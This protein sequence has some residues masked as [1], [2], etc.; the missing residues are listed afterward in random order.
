[1]SRMTCRPCSRPH[2]LL[3][4]AG[5]ARNEVRASLRGAPSPPFEGSSKLR[6]GEKLWRRGGDSRGCNTCRRSVTFSRAKAAQ[7][8]IGEEPHRPTSKTPFELPPGVGGGGQSWPRSV[9]QEGAAMQNGTDLYVLDRTPGPS[10][11]ASG[12]T[13]SRFGS[14]T[15]TTR[16]PPGSTCL[17]S[18]QLNDSIQ[19]PMRRTA[20][21]RTPRVSVAGRG[22][23]FPEPLGAQPDLSP[24]MNREFRREAWRLETLPV[25]RVPQEEEAIRAY[26]AGE[27]VDLGCSTR[28]T[29]SSCTTRQTVRRSDGKCSRAM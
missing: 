22:D 13:H 20:L 28:R 3:A 19:E 24:Q 12:L 5:A 9:E 6:V 2:G 21:P 17:S 16:T 25:Y 4:S 23:M 29:S 14:P 11:T 15:P 10:V 7:A 26:L 27:R 1:M 8:G 18:Q